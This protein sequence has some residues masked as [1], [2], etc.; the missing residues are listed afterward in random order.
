MAGTRSAGAQEGGLVPDCVV[1]DKA[2]IQKTLPPTEPTGHIWV[3]RQG[4]A[5]E[6]GGRAPRYRPRISRH[7]AVRDA[8]L[9]Q[10]RV[11]MIVCILKRESRPVRRCVIIYAVAYARQPPEDL[12]EIASARS[13]Q[14]IGEWVGSCD[15]EGKQRE[16]PEAIPEAI[17]NRVV[18]WVLEQWFAKRAIK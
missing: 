15:H 8:A 9:R 6:E 17:S 2:N 3:G 5:E 10:D 7:V 12:Q 13:A 16:I 18:M 1:T 11:C 14:I 4:K